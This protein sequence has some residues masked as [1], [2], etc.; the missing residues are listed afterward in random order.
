VA[1]RR[2]GGL[3]VS[4]PFLV[5]ALVLAVP[6]VLIDSDHSLGMVVSIPYYRLICITSCVQF[7]QTFLSMNAP[8]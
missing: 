1:D 6:F 5:V 8:N 4:G 7:A 2:G 3:L